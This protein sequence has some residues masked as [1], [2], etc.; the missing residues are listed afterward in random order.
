[1]PQSIG[2]FLVDGQVSGTWKPTGELT[3]FADVDKSPVEQE[4]AR[5]AEFIA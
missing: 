2:T 5:L 3:Y 4:A 1:M